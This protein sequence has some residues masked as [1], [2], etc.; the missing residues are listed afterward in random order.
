MPTLAPIAFFA[1]N[2]PEH[3][4]LALESLAKNDLAAQSSLWIYIDGPKP[5]ATEETKAAI[6]EVRKVVLE[7][8]WCKEVTIIAA[9]VNKGLFKSNIEG[10]TKIVIIL[11]IN[12]GNKKVAK[13][14]VFLSPFSLPPLS[15]PT[16]LS[17]LP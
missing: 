10:V 17:L 13:S 2:R 9:E 4:R 16:S 7:K 6:N 15:L 14:T 8:K 1:Y 5:G 3:T 12:E 11:I